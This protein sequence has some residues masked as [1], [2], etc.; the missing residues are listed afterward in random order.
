MQKKMR[1]LVLRD[2]DIVYVDVAS[3][4]EVGKG[5]LGPRGGSGGQPS[6]KALLDLGFKMKEWNG[7]TTVLFVDNCSGRIV[8]MLVGHGNSPD[9][10]IKFKTAEQYLKEARTRAKF[11]ARQMKHRRGRYGSVTY[12]YSFGGGQKRPGFLKTGGPLKSGLAARLYENSHIKSVIG[13]HNKC[14]WTFAPRLA[15]RYHRLLS[16]LSK[17]EKAKKSSIFN[18]QPE[19]DSFAAA[20]FNLGPS[21]STELHYDSQN[22]G[23]GLCVISSFGQYDYKKGG[24][25]ILWEMGVVVEFPPYSTILIPSAV[26]K[27]GNIA[28]ADGEE[29]MSITQYTAGALV[30]WA[31]RGFKSVKV[32]CGT[33][34]LKAVDC[35]MSMFMTLEELEASQKEGM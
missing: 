17:Y 16:F 34:L 33:K 27:H 25:L 8:T 2:V 29:R 1:I 19:T 32:H 22:F 26:I 30:R 6:L 7:R 15:Y 35:P 23:P 24:H 4:K 18:L 12:G 31:A 5:Y 28:V 9:H 14:L 13:H 20:T 3:R 21:V 11:T 10:L